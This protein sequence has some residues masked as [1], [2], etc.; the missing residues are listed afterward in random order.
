[1]AK[2]FTDT[3]K[4][5]REW[6][7]DLKPH[8]K[9]AW[10]YLLDQCDHCGIWPRN[11]R[12]MGEQVGFKMDHQTMSDW[13]GDK[14]IL[15]DD[16]KYFIPSFFE[17]QYGSSK[18]GFKARNSALVKLQNLNLLDENA[19]LKCTEH[20]PK[21]SEQSP[22]CLSIGI[23]IGKSTSIGKSN[24]KEHFDFETPYQDY[25]RKIGKSDGLKKLRAEIRT[26]TD[27]DA[28]HQAVKN[29]KSFCEKENKSKEYIKHFDSF[30]SS[31]RDWLDPLTGTTSINVKREKTFLELM[32]EKEAAGA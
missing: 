11:F 32:A 8:A 31:W 14:I 18:D 1:M 26:R 25:P 27:F 2:R 7:Y 4:W 20:L 13:F 29:Y 15:F 21:C 30:V 28:F 23:G 24:T 19:K 3:D 9:L 16:D 5:K 22:D 12:L 10:L 6:F 17:F